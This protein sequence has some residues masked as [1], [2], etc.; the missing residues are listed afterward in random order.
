MYVMLP[1]WIIWISMCRAVFS[2]QCS[3]C[4]VQCAVSS[5]QCPVFSVQWALFRVQCA[6]CSV[7]CAVFSVQWALFRVQ[8][9]VC[10]KN[11]LFRCSWVHYVHWKRCDVVCVMCY[12]RYPGS[13]HLIGMFRTFSTK[14]VTSEFFNMWYFLRYVLYAMCDTEAEYT[15]PSMMVPKLWHLLWSLLSRKWCPPDSQTESG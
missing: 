1:W 9:A 14:G 6:V 10:R 15:L 7:Q 11:A 5:V 3:V 12:G 13:H 2:V 8:C 4:S